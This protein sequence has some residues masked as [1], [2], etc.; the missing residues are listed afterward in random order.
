MCTD[1]WPLAVNF[2]TCIICLTQFSRLWSLISTTT[3]FLSSKQ[4]SRELRSDILLID[5]LP[6]IC[7]QNQIL[8]NP[9]P[10]PW[11]WRHQGWGVHTT[12]RC[13]CWWRGEYNCG[14]QQEWQDPGKSQECSD[15]ER[16]NFFYLCL[17]CSLPVESFSASLAL[18]GLALASLT[19]LVG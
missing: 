16:F 6:I 11:I 14:R 3:D 9:S 2:R 10:V 7:L 1:Q 17:R 8:W 19:G 18:R 12:Q 5:S 15:L 4:I 13:H